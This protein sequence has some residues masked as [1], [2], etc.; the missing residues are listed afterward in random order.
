MPIG[1]ADPAAAKALLAEA[2]HPDGLTVPLWM[3]AQQPLL[4]R[5]GVA[6]REL[7]KPAN[8]AVEIHQVPE[9]QYNAAQRPLM[10]NSFFAR[11]TP[12]TIL[13]EWY[14]TNGSWNRNNWRY[15]NPEVDRILDT[16]RQTSDAAEQKRLYSRFQE[17][18]VNE[19]PGPVLFVVNHATGVSN[20]VRGFSASRL[21]VLNLKAVT[22]AD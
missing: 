10:I 19:G 8:L 21:S 18:A 16:A 11:T 5:M 1:K 9:D 17:I 4:E 20:R 2:G 22:L 7:A 14:H 6:L 15:S 12:D 13:Y 3:P